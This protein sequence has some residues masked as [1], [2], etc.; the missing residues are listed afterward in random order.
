MAVHTKERMKANSH[1]GSPS[2]GNFKNQDN[3]SEKTVDSRSNST[4]NRLESPTPEYSKSP[5]PVDDISSDRKN[6]ENSEP[7]TDSLCT[8]EAMETEALVSKTAGTSSDSITNATTTS[9][10][11]TV[12]STGEVAV[13]NSSEL[14]NCLSSNTISSP[15][16]SSTSIQS[17]T[18]NDSQ[19]C[20]DDVTDAKEKS[21]SD[22]NS[23]EN[24][25]HS[26]SESAAK[27][28]PSDSPVSVSSCS[29]DPNAEPP[30]K[31]QKTCHDTEGN[32]ARMNGHSDSC[33]DISV[34]NMTTMGNE[35]YD[36]NSHN[37]NSNKD[38]NL[39]SSGVPDSLSNGDNSDKLANKTTEVKPEPMDVD[40]KEESSDK[41]IKSEQDESSK[42]VKSEDT[43]SSG[44]IKSQ[45]EVD[46]KTSIKSEQEDTG[47]SDSVKSGEKETGSTKE[48]Y[49]ETTTNDVKFEKEEALGD[50][51]SKSDVFEEHDPSQYLPKLEEFE[52]VA[53]SVEELRKLVLK[54]GDLPPK[55][56]KEA[57]KKEGEDGE[58]DNDG[59]DEE[60]E[61]K[62][63]SDSDDDVETEKQVN[64][65]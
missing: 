63:G 59:D 44:D 13:T 60:K 36:T 38:K 48:G 57:K 16:V 51:A 1:E 30:V 62:D 65:C 46:D 20:G 4:E 6:D 9:Q 11:D 10:A 2:P 42:A 47:S 18:S 34:N 43:Y 61:E 45:E 14:T 50:A 15:T 27:A 41:E 17:K 52:L 39:P 24:N 32:L 19:K 35:S 23:L 7:K 40:I 5:S 37:V 31:K 29:N 54:F 22:L 25:A 3:S 64:Y 28:S 56:A 49:E 58:A 8:S 55:S 12:S 33:Q 26:T 21:K 53:T